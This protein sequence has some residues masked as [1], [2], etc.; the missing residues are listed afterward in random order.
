MNKIEKR[1]RKYNI[2]RLTGEIEISTSD[3]K[4]SL[5]QWNVT[6]QSEWADKLNN[7]LV[8]GH[9][10]FP[11]DIVL[12]TWLWETDVLEPCPIKTLLNASQLTGLIF[13]RHFAATHDEFHM[14]SNGVAEYLFGEKH[15][16]VLE[17][18]NT[19]VNTL[20]LRELRDTVQN[21]QLHWIETKAVKIKGIEMLLYACLHR[22]G[23][24][25]ATTF[26][27]FILNDQGSIEDVV[28]DEEELRLNKICIRRF[29]NVFLILFRHVK[30]EM[31]SIIVETPLELPELLIGTHQILAAS[32]DFGIFSMNWDLIPSAKLNYIHD[33]PGMYNS[34]SQV[35]YFHNP[36]YERRMQIRKELEKYSSG[37][38]EA[39]QLL[40][41]LMQLYPEIT[42]IYEEDVIPLPGTLSTTGAYTWLLVGKVVYLINPAGYIYQ[43]PN[44]L[45]LLSVYLKHQI[46]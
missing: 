7:V 31:K 3:I 44:L 17:I 10:K 22:F 41:C 26:S 42:L 29:I 6:V 45:V 5:R 1:K 39:V 23:V 19:P 20:N 11:E 28:G 38:I 13:A 14:N 15:N 12:Q 43:H 21:L 24:L 8:P 9:H 4:I 2:G 25:A 35:V 46:A 34:I 27:S 33:F 36:K 40:P 30:I 18:F 16:H 37:T 32:D